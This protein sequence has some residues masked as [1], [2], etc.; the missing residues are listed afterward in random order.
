MSPGEGIYG[1][2]RPC[3]RLDRTANTGTF[4]NMNSHPIGRL[5]LLILLIGPLLACVSGTRATGQPPVGQDGDEPRY[6]LVVRNGRIVDG[7]GN[8]WFYGDVAVRDDRIAFVGSLSEGSYLTDNELDARGLVV[9]PGFIDV[10]THADRALHRLPKAE[11][12]IHDGVTTIVTG[13]CGSSVTDVGGYFRRLTDDGVALNVATLI[14]HNS[15]LRDVKGNVAG[16]LSP[17]QMNEA[18]EIVEKAMR[19]GAVGMSTGL[20]YTPG[21]WSETEEIIELQK[22]ASKH[23]G[24]YA[25]H[26][27]SEGK[28]I[29]SAIEE[30]LRI[31]D[32]TDSRIQISHFKV[33]AD[34]RD[35]VGGSDATLKKVA[36]A[37]ANGQEVW[38]DQYP[39]SASSTSITTLLPGWV[40]EE[41][42]EEARRILADP[43]QVGR[44][45]DDMRKQF[46]GDRKRTSM[47]YVFISS[48]RG[49]P[50]YNGKNLKE[51]AQLMKL[52]GE[53]GDEAGGADA[54]E[55][56]PLPEVSMEDQ[57]RA[58]FDIIINGGASCVFHSMV[59]EDVENILRH[60]L[61]GIASDSGVREPGEGVPH[62]RGY[63]TNA[64]VLGR[65]A[66][67]LGVVTLEDA[68][69]KMTSLPATAFRFTDRGLVR[70]GYIADLTI[71]DPATVNDL[72]TFEEPH[73]YSTGITHV[74]VNG[75]LV[76][77][78]GEMTDA[79]PGRP[80]AGPGSRE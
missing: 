58:A 20:I 69:R 9:A 35:R 37:R 50:E 26:M 13:N 55:T 6:D 75:T 30:A 77:E 7:T 24:I 64:R 68:I 47:D 18:K 21:Q 70:E 15:V 22:I 14:G 44:V 71:F 41:G 61:V 79:L 39:Y 62:P 65:F 73:Q 78:D 51:I 8:A 40:L 46:E 57:Y 1:R 34:Y 54:A 43:E 29:I 49:Y 60:P 4:Y 67:E 25:T 28:G 80:V 63:G 32:E 27:R 33:V 17:E 31:G 74:I 59:E 16:D 10:H 5:A 45:L 52:G 23:G 72:A 38:L 66:R 76:L 36:D 48:S 56:Q 53:Q 19:D 42:I 3:T 11:N 2:G 12:F